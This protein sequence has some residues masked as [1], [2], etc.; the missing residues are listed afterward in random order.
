MVISATLAG[1]PNWIYWYN[2]LW[3]TPARLL[4]YDGFQ[5]V[6]AEESLDEA[7]AV[8]QE[9]LNNPCADAESL[10]VR[11]DFLDRVLGFFLGLVLAGGSPFALRRRQWRPS[12]QDGHNLP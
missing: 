6:V 10:T 2:A 3:N 8:L 1:I 12:P 11:G 7:R 4:I 9:A 5:I